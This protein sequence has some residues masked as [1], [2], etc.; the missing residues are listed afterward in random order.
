MTLTKVVELT[1]PGRAAI[2]VVLV[3]GPGATEA[4]SA[5]FSPV[6]S[7]GLAD[8]PLGRIVL[9]HWGG[10]EGEEL[11]ACRRDEE[12]IEIHCHGGTAAVRAVI[13][14]LVDRGCSAISWQEWLRSPRSRVSPKLGSASR[15]DA[16]TDSAQIALAS[17]PTLRTA[18]VLLDQYHGALSRA[19]HVLREAITSAD[20]V[21]AFAVAENTLRFRDVGLHLTTPWRVVIAGAPNVG[22]SSLVNALAGYQRAIVSPLPGTT[23]DVVTLTTAIDGW[24]VEFADTAGLRSSDDE[25]ESAGVALAEAA[26]VEADLVILVSDSCSKSDADFD[27]AKRVPATARL[28]RA[29]NKID[30][31]PPADRRRLHLASSNPQSAIRNPQ[32]VSALTGEGIAELITAIGKALIPVAPPPGTAVPFT[33]EQVA[34]LELAQTAIEGRDASAAEAALN[35][36]LA[37]GGMKDE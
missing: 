19:I 34:S 26:L 11:I 12:E 37:G 13:D 32:L 2:A 20:W 28:I 17:A 36:L 35:A 15:R 5:C 7:R 8:L 25:L 6:S 24:P 4:V 33:T 22:K 30:L 21:R 27:V 10:P 1:P 31:V 23:R 18:A 29:W 14:R 9:G 3:A 16:T